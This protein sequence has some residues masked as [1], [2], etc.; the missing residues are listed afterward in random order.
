MQ[1]WCLDVMV[2][3]WQ[4]LS[5]RVSSNKTWDEAAWIQRQDHPS[6]KKNTCFGKS[7]M[8][9]YL[10]YSYGY[11]WI[12]MDIYGYLWI[13]MDIY[14]YL[15]IFMDIYGYLWIFMDIYGYLWIFMDIYGYLWIFMDIYGLSTGAYALKLT[16]FGLVVQNSWV[17]QRG[18]SLV[19]V[20]RWN[21]SR[22]RWSFGIQHVFLLKDITVLLKVLKSCCNKP[23]V[24][25]CPHWT[26]PN[27]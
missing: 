27:H 17:R 21:P 14:G 18:S 9:S 15:W 23:W 6:V 26:S 8:P 3:S 25:K 19:G 16:K 7:A 2:S 13:F 24:I 20:H 5:P 1:P 22:S 4:P 10:S 11:L 12:F